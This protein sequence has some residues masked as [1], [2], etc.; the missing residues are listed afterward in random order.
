MK[1]QIVSKSGLVIEEYNNLKTAKAYLKQAEKKGSPKG[2]LTI[3]TE[4]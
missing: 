1:Y 4:G 2:Y 3:R